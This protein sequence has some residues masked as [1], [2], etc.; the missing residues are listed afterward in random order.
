MGNGIAVGNEAIVHT[1]RDASEA[2]E[3]NGHVIFTI[4]ASN[5]FN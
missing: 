4:D 1:L 2:M 3:M 5:A